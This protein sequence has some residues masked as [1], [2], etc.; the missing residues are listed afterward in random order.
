MRMKSILKALLLNAI[1]L[2]QLYI[3]A[4]ANIQAEVTPG[5]LDEAFKRCVAKCAMIFQ[6]P[7]LR[8]MCRVGC[9]YGIYENMR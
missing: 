9:Y 2:S 4:P 7:F 1:L 3:L 8:D 6:D 5:Y